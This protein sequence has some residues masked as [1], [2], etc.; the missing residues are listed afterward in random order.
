MTDKRPADV[1]RLSQGPAFN[2]INTSPLHTWMEHPGL[3]PN[4][5]DEHK[6]IFD[7]GTAAHQWILEGL[8]ATDNPLIVIVEGFTDYKKKL[9][10]QARDA[11][12][13]EGK[14]PLLEHQV[15]SLEAMVASYRRQFPDL[16]LG[17]PERGEAED[18]IRWED[19][20][21]IVCSARLDWVPTDGRVNY[22]LKTDGQT[23]QPAAWA[24]NKL[25][26]GRNL[27]QAAFYVEAWFHATGE[28]RKVQF[29]VVENK[30]PYGASLVSLSNHAMH[31]ADAMMWQAKKVWKECLDA[32][33]WPSYGTEA[34]DV[35]PPAWLAREWGIVE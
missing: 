31:I 18:Y 17:D 20:A 25:W 26:S 7:L 5:Q 6:L 35:S 14:M 2:I 15:A 32:N 29:V 1:P 13:A 19:D 33:K 24:R 8:S 28:M 22:E 11:A 4:R 16:G 3:N 34:V 27:M 21:G 10:Q 30:P 12:W 9:A 23:A